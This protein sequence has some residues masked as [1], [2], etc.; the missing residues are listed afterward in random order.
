MKNIINP[1]LILMLIMSLSA[2]STISDIVPL[3]SITL[4]TL[5]RHALPKGKDIEL[6]NALL[7]AG[8]KREAATAYFDASRNYRSPERERLT[9]Q[10]AEL[11]AIIKDSSLA[12]RYLS[13]LRY[14]SLNPENQARFRFT[15]AQMALNDKNFREALRILP[16]R[17][18]GL[19]DGLASKILNA[20]MRAAQSSRDRISLVQELVLQERTLK[21]DYEVKLNHDRIWNHI[22]QMP[23][24]T[25]NTQRKQIN[26]TVLK[27]WL[28]LGYL[29]RLAKDAGDISPTARTNLKGWQQRNLAHPGNRKVAEILKSAPTATVTPYSTGK[30][31]PAK[32]SAADMPI[33]TSGKQIAVILPLTGQLASLGNTLLKGI[34]AAHKQSGK[35]TELKVYNST[36]S[37]IEGLYKTAVNRGADFV[38]GPF[39]K[40][41]IAS[42]AQ[43]ELSRP[44]LG[45]NYISNTNN[46]AKLKQFGL[47]PEDEAVQM[48]QFALSQGKKRV[49]ILTPNSAWGNRLRDAM[50]RAVI[51][52]GGKVVITKSYLNTALNYL[53]DAQNL[54]YR[55]D[56]L[57][58]I[59]MAAAPSQARILYPTLRQEIKNLPIYASSHVFNGVVNPSEDA[60][61]DGLIFT[62]TPWILEAVQKRIKPTSAYPRLHAMGM[63]AY[64]VATSLKSLQSFGSSL[65]GK[66]G[67][68]RLSKDGTLH[69]TL[70]WAQFRN[71]VP[72]SLR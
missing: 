50:R 5:D 39:D 23:R 52:R 46:A 24:Q 40:N 63:D 70:R 4:P 16:Q 57:D 20:R 62:E 25:L 12:Q 10:A 8:K 59:L 49:A 28:D 48:A 36:T 27:N 35:G 56:E 64:R 55:S 45:L 7:A 69:R 47:L 43:L 66:T 31:K 65:N 9:L 32:P 68:I 41:R 17:V 21:N 30:N 6:A 18:N 22:Q 53:P 2:C 61:L 44:V 58:A 14:A 54:A 1:V 11:A 3:P 15:Q 37:S 38:I 42:L 26:H 34:Q 33:K 13:P 60:K 51:E 29:A 19:P 72:I 67:R 71:G